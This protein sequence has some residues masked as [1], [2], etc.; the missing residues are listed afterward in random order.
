MSSIAASVECRSWSRRLPIRQ[1]G[2]D[3]R[4]GRA[5]GATAHASS[6]RS[7]VAGLTI[8]ARKHRLAH[9]AYITLYMRLSL[10]APPGPSKTTGWLTAGA[11]FLL[12]RQL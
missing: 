4:N 11:F 10:Y 12:T 6:T 3:P 7:S 9:A 5:A 2:L 8:I 1:G